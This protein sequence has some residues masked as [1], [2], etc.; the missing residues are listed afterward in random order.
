MAAISPNSTK[1]RRQRVYS[2]AIKKGM[3]VR[4]ER[5]KGRD[6]QAGEGIL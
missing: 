1:N 5:S 2:V 3:R 4:R 6:V